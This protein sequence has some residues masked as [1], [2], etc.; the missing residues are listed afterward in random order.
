MSGTPIKK[1]YIATCDECGHHLNM[2]DSWGCLY[3]S[4]DCLVQILPEDAREKNTH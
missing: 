2:H 3:R 1:R 4:C